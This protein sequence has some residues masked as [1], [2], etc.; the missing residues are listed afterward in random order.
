[1]KFP[2]K[3]PKFAFTKTTKYNPK[4]ETNFTGEWKQL[5]VGDH[6]NETDSTTI[7]CGGAVAAVDWAP[8]K[9]KENFLA[10]ACNKEKQGIKMRLEKAAPAFIQIYKFGNLKNDQ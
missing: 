4:V 8:T 1:L 3:S 10:V 7:Y 9:N 5:E 6:V 2:V